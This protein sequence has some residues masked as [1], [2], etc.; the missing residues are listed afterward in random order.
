MTIDYRDGFDLEYITL[1]GG[2]TEAEAERDWLHAEAIYHEAFER[3]TKQGMCL[4]NADK[5]A[6]AQVQKTYPQFSP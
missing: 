3:A 4:S 1:D 6:W 5:H 2:V